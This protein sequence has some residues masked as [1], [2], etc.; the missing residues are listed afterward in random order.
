MARDNATAHNEVVKAL[1]A[2]GY[3]YNGGSSSSSAR[4]TTALASDPISSTVI[5]VMQTPMPERYEGLSDFG[6]WLRRY[7]ADGRGTGWS[8]S[9]LTERLGNYLRGDVNDWYT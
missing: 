8:D 5:Q 7:E 4:G 9:Q 3:G 6:D 1:K 2:M